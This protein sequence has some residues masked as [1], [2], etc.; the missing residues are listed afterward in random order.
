MPEK[1][2]GW[3]TADVWDVIAEIVPSARSLVHG[4]EVRTWA[5]FEARA[6]SVSTALLAA[7]LGRQDKVGLYLWNG[8]EYM[9]GTYAAL[10][11]SLV[12][13]NVNYRYRG[14]E[15]RHLLEDAD[16]AAVVFHGSFTE[17]I[18]ELRA[19]LRGVR[20]YIHVDDGTAATPPWAIPYEAAATSGERRLPG[21]ERSGDDL[22]L[23]YTGGTTGQPKGVMWRQD[24]LY[25]LVATAGDSKVADL[26]HVRRRVEAGVGATPIGLALP[27]LMHATASMFASNQ[28]Y[29]GGTVV[30]LPNRSFDA[31]ATLDA[32]VRESVTAVVI[33]GDAFGRPL[34]DALDAAPG[35]WELE[36]LRL[37]S[38]SGAMW[39]EGVK[40][41]LLRHA[42]NA[43]LVDLLG[44]SEASGLGRSVASSTRAP[45]T[46]EFKLGKRACVIGEE[47]ELIEAGSGRVGRLAVRGPMP[48]GYYK[49]PA[50]TA[51]AFPVIRGERYSVPGDYATVD[52]NGGIH[53]LGRG[54][55]TINT[56]GEKVFAEEVEEALKAHPEVAD[57]VV[58][59]VPDERFGQVV[60]AAVQIERTAPRTVTSDGL[61][62]HVKSRLA[63]YKAPRSFVFVESI[64][65]LDNGKVDLPAVRQ[66]LQERSSENDDRS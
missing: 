44:S 17:Q 21:W 56:G 32:L 63:G 2:G 16:I 40:E 1:T 31:G 3:N 58:L 64:P 8:P 25:Q 10:K 38:S 4:D 41:R 54:S 11:A 22:F 20:C 53:L 36:K 15:L 61:A 34:A 13:V 35:R 59:G 6:A 47:G 46:A 29:Q 49:D 23:M 51:R 37:M 5:Q 57:V 50:G 24:D 7:G 19:T 65:R 9:E 48:L 18:S 39:S 14:D 12:P 45:K 33:V 62:A 42:P 52:E 26:D 66:R 27:P 60:A 43:L 30:T 28:L 55:S